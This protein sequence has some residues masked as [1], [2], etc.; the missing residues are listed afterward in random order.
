MQPC[1]KSRNQCQCQL[2]NDDSIHWR[3]RYCG[4]ADLSDFCLGQSKSAVIIW[5]GF[6]PF[7][8]LHGITYEIA[9]IRSTTAGVTAFKLA[10]NQGIKWVEGRQL[11]P[12][13]V[14]LGCQRRETGPFQPPCNNLCLVGYS[15]LN[16][17]KNTVQLIQTRI[18]NHQFPFTFGIVLDGNSRAQSIT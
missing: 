11:P 6:H 5:A 17:I 14:E 7:N 13:W 8:L 15:L 4:Q 1:E 12:P 18:I 2:Q 3:T 10:I 9:L 16:V